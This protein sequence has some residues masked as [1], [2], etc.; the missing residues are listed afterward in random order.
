MYMYTEEQL[1]SMK[2]VEATRQE[3]FENLFPRMSAEEKETV[4]KEMLVDSPLSDDTKEVILSLRRAMP[5]GRALPLDA[6]EQ[7]CRFIACTQNTLK[8]GVAEAIDRAVCL[9]AAPYLLGTGKQLDQVKPL[10]SAMPRTL[11]ALK[12]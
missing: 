11:K 7:M 2:K 3:R 9:Y 10:L 1:A 12:Q 6:V 8:G 4:L 5:E